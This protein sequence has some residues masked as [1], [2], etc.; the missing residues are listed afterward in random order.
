MTFSSILKTTAVAGLMGLGFT[1]TTAAPADAAT[2][3]RCNYNGCYRVHCD[4]RGYCYRTG[5]YRSDY[6]NESYYG[7]Y[8]GAYFSPYYDGDYYY[9]AV[10]VC[11]GYGCRWTRHRQPRVHVGIGLRF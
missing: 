11:D 10:R 9:S 8:S 2:Y 1:A 6:Y 3:Q 5:D 7:G 4:Y